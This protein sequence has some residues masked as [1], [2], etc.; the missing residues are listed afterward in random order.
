MGELR[1]VAAHVVAVGIES[2]ALADGVEDPVV[3]RG[4]GAAAGRPLPAV[5]VAR[6]IPVA[7]PAHE[8]CR[9]P[10]PRQV[11]VLDEEARDNHAHAIVHPSFS[12]Q[13]AH[14]GV[15]EGIARAAL[16]PRLEERVGLR[17]RIPR[18]VV[19]EARVH[20]GARALGALM[21]HVGV[22][23]PPR[24]LLAEGLLA[25]GVAEVGENRARVDLTPLQV[26]AHGRR[27]IERREIA[28]VVVGREARGP[29]GRPA[30][31]CRGLARRG[32][33]EGQVGSLGESV[34]VHRH[35]VRRLGIRRGRAPAV[36]HPRAVEGRVDAVRRAV[37]LRHSTG[38]DGVWRARLHELDAVLG[39]GG[40]HARIPL[41]A[42]GPVVGGDVHLAR[43]GCASDRDDAI[44]GITVLQEELA[45]EV[46]V[47]RAQRVDEVGAAHIAGGLPHGGVDDEERHHLAVDGGGRSECGVVTQAQVAAEPGDG[48]HPRRLEAGRPGGTRGRRAGEWG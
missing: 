32:Q 37:V 20:G 8:V 46:G 3:R 35:G 5:G 10:L 44:D 16:G 34:A 24:D 9:P 23:L 2:L 21:H 27:A 29:E 22:E 45:V 6:Q 17:T 15:D 39:E 18:E 19:V 14:A 12:E 47:E 25:R 30:L 48:G 31:E 1:H 4:V 40:A 7:Q 11:Q 28:G 26:M 36:A 33:R 43:V 13:L 38:R 41:Y 42:V